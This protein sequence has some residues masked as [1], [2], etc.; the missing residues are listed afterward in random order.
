ME[1]CNGIAKTHN[2]SPK[3]KTYYDKQEKYCQAKNF[4]TRVISRETDIIKSRLCVEKA[5][6]SLN[7][8]AQW[9]VHIWS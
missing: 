2:L 6:I 8:S 5:G 4:V 3:L 1:I 7:L 9:A